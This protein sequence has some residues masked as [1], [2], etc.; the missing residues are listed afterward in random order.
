MG[1]SSSRKLKVNIDG[2][3]MNDCQKVYNIE[4]REISNT[5]ICAGGELGYDSW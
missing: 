2:M 4:N 5:Q 3:S 1:F